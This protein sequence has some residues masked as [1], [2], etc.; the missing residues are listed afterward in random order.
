[1]PRTPRM[2][3]A[4]LVFSAILITSSIAGAAAPV[5]GDRTGHDA[6]IREA[7]T[8]IGLGT[9]LIGLTRIRRRRG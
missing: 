5:D 8:L 3:V 4:A 9:G 6:S 7:V 2:W 1:M